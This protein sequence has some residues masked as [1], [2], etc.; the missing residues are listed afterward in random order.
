M[1]A[2]GHGAEAAALQRNGRTAEKLVELDGVQPLLFEC[3][4][5]V[6]VLFTNGLF[7]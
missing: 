7:A 3:A 1:A 2:D 4:R 6:G 5:Y